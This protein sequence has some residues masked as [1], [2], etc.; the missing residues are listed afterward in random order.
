MNRKHIPFV[1]ILGPLRW[2]GL[3][4]GF[5]GAITAAVSAQYAAAWPRGLVFA[6]LAIGIGSGTMLVLSYQNP[7]WVTTRCTVL[8][9][10]GG[11]IGC[12]LGLLLGGFFRSKSGLT[13]R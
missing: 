5:V 11:A 2:P 6:V 12:V 8:V 1:W 9:A 10:A 7:W 3:F 4:V 13:K